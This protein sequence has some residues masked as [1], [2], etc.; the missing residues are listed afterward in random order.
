M[1]NSSKY[2]R[3]SYSALLAYEIPA[4]GGATEFSDSRTAYDDLPQEK[5]E[6]I[7]DMVILHSLWQSRK[8]ASPGYEPNEHERKVRPGARHKLVQT[9]ALGRKVLIP[10][11]QL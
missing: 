5:K 9:D 2:P 3:Y 6:E 1:D 7:E 11:F 10:L 8:M 4:V